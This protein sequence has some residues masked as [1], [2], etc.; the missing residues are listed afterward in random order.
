MNHVYSIESF[1]I[2]TQ[3][4]AFVEEYCFISRKAGRNSVFGLAPSAVFGWN[5][6]V[7]HGK[8]NPT[9]DTKYGL[10]SF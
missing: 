2:D 5:T 3:N 9:A 4:Q 6:K 7:K 1:N 10:K 8:W